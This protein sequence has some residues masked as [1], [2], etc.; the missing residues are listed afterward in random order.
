MQY[1]TM[2]RRRT[3][4]RLMTGEVTWW[5]TKGHVSENPLH[6]GTCITG[7]GCLQPFLWSSV[8][9]LWL[10]HP[11]AVT[12][13]PPSAMG[14]QVFLSLNW[15][16]IAVSLLSHMPITF[17]HRHLCVLHLQQVPK[18]FCSQ[19]NVLE[20]RSPLLSKALPSAPLCPEKAVLFK[21]GKNLLKECMSVLILTK[22]WIIDPSSDPNAYHK[23][24]NTQ[25]A[26]LN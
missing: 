12:I 4:W 22:S 16:L 6:G 18:F 10:S 21:E 20:I 3:V 19:I 13:K 15:S 8:S 24:Y 1:R 26:K 25:R 7:Q 5:H 9:L 17:H 23:G 14:A 2:Q 11:P